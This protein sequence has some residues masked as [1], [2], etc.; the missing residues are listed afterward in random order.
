MPT[1]L[2]PDDFQSTCSP[3][4]FA[5]G[6]GGCIYGS[7][8]CD[9]WYDCSDR[10]DELDCGGVAEFSCPYDTYTCEGAVSASHCLDPEK[11]CDEVED[12]PNG[13]DEGYRCTEDL[14]DADNGGCS[15]KCKPSPHGAWCYCDDGYQVTPDDPKQ[16]VD[17]D[18]CA[19]DKCSQYCS[20]FEGSYSCDCDSNYVNIVGSC[21]ERQE[22]WTVMFIAHQ[23]SLWS[24]DMSDLTADAESIDLPSDVYVNAVDGNSHTEILYYTELLSRSIR[25]VKFNGSDHKVLFGMGIGT[26]EDLAVD[27]VSNLIYWTDYTFETITVG[28]LDGGYRS[29]LFGNN[30][31]NPRSIVLENSPSVQSIWW[32]DWGSHPRVERA[33]QDGSGRITIL[34]DKLYWPNG[35]AIDQY[36]KRLY[37]MDSRLD[38]I[39]YCDYDGKNRIR[40]LSNVDT[41]DHPWHLD[42][43]ED[44]LFWTDY[45]RQSIE[46]C[47]K[48]DC[49][50][51][52][53]YATA[54]DG[55]RN[56]AIVSQGKQKLYANPCA[57]ANCAHICLP[58][59]RAEGYVCRCSTG[60][61]VNP[62]DETKCD[63]SA[64][65]FIMF[66]RG[67]T[68]LGQP[69]N[70]SEEH[71]DAF[72]PIIVN[73]TS[74]TMFDYDSRDN[75]I[76][77]VEENH[78]R[79]A[80]LNG[81]G[82]EDFLPHLTSGPEAFVIDWLARNIY[83]ADW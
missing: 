1:Y 39:D 44:N 64:E 7:W 3:D 81:S 16:C 15:D 18:E 42:M 25:S 28:S 51:G 65:D 77:W 43:F 52:Q 63:E 4:E 11:V 67:T 62:S 29:V 14:C 83:Y 70:S 45:R 8:Q 59:Q 68:I 33:N 73:Q 66:S 10:S 40:V 56:L 27:W 34:S 41:I 53:R 13:D 76:Y 20:N 24:I 32:T 5:C 61:T 54:G 58:S 38:F 57:S 46:M 19:E 75:F 9:G 6:G 2:T 22:L 12:C 74:Y 37:V 17:I 23:T 79:R 72:A 49:A 78:T 26:P 69:F 47:S 55:L 31:T 50:K 60:Y 21:Y 30:I 82:T 36:K 80:H 48:T 71:F 35:L